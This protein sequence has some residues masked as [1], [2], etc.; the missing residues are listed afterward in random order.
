MRRV[1]EFLLVM[2]EG[3]FTPENQTDG[4][5]T[6]QGIL[7]LDTTDSKVSV[8]DCHIVL[9]VVVVEIEEP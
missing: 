2:V 3:C 7:A 9:V 8:I 4:P 5:W 1:V 6:D